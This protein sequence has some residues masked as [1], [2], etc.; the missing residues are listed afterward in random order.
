MKKLLEADRQEIYEAPI[1]DWNNN[2]YTPIS[3]KYIMDL[4]EEQI[5]KAGLIVKNTH[6]TAS[7][8]TENKVKGVIGGYDIMT[9]DEEFGQRLMFRNSYVFILPEYART[10]KAMYPVSFRRKKNNCRIENTGSVRLPF[11]C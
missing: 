1:I 8:T 4:I 3:N 5:D 2:T 9:D 10:V 6:F 7:R 11:V